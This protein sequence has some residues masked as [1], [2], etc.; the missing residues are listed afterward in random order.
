M[1]EMGN[2]FATMK[3]AGQ[4]ADRVPR[5]TD[6]FVGKVEVEKMQYVHTREG[7]QNLFFTNLKILESNM[8]EHPV[9][10]TR[11][12]CQDRDKDAARGAF[13]DFAAAALGFQSVKSPEF[14]EMFP[15]DDSFSAFLATALDP[16]ENKDYGGTGSLNGAV[17]IVEAHNIVTKNNE[18][19]WAKDLAAGKVTPDSKPQPFLAL[20]FK[21]AT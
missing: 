9:G 19:K 18:T 21:P 8:K 1:D 16:V 4:R 5:F 2:P 10:A 13:Q 3:P 15:D 7:N 12:W 20:R 14:V 11:S 6:G 17:L